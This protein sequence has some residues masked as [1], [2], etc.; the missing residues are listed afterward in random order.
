MNKETKEI[1]LV[2]R[3]REVLGS[4]SEVLGEQLTL[5]VSK[6][7]LSRFNK[8]EKEYDAFYE[9]SIE[10]RLIKS[11]TNKPREDKSL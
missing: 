4:L 2:G 1:M 10:E 5:Q 11:C 8:L 6:E 3:L 9:L 7:G